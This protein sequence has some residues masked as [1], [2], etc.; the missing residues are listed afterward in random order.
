V[1]P[2]R[3]NSALPPSSGIGAGCTSMHFGENQLSP[4]SIG[5]S[6]LP[7]THPNLLQQIP[8]RPFTRCYAR[9]SL[10]MG[11][12]H[13]FRSAACHACALHTRF[14]SASG[15]RCLKRA[16]HSNSSGH[17]P[18]GT[19]SRLLPK[20]PR[21]LTAWTRSVS[22]SVSLPSPGYFSPFPHGTVRYRSRPV[23]RL[24]PWSAPLPTGLL[25]SGG[26]RDGSPG[27]APPRYGTITRSGVAFQPLRAASVPA[28]LGKQPQREVSQPRARN[29][30]SLGTCTVWATARFAR[31]YSGRGSISSG[32]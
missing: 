7:T 27:E 20:E 18:K 24:G 10:V 28:V 14:R 32:Y 17:S 29:A 2:P 11:S 19:R 26:T 23:A 16:T 15:Y 3:R 8:V 9:C 5:I 25:V 4:C 1:K 30:C 21:A 22:G 13:G 12:S 31:H 6:P